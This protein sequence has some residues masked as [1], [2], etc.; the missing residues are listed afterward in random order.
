MRAAFTTWSQAL[1]QASFPAELRIGAPPG[2]DLH[3]T[4]A[5]LGELLGS[6]PAATEEPSAGSNA[7]DPQFLRGLAT[8]LWRLEKTAA[9]LDDSGASV[10]IHSRID[11]L[12]G[13][14][15]E[16]G[17]TTIDFS[18][19]AFDANEIWD[20]VIGTQEEKRDPVI[21]SMREPRVVY[22]GTVIQRGLP[23]IEDRTPPESH[24]EA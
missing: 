11:M 9:R 5:Q 17:V 8:H 6:A 16:A 20:D 2:D 3:L 13:L 22:Q 10:R 14:L 1:R 23:V 7:P 15:K 12:S 19:R 4:P 18:G 24:E 21:A